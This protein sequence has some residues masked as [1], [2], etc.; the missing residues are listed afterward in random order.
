MIKK[1]DFDQTFSHQ[2]AEV[3]GVKL[4]LVK[5]GTGR[6]G[7]FAARLS[8]DVILVVSNY[9]RSCRTL[10]SH[11]AGFARDGCFVKA[12]ERL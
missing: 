6:A 12:R 9:A 8:A 7:S 3:S 4:H 2:M 1:T 5:G 10:H 11:R